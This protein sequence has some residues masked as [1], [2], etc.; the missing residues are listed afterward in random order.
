MVNITGKIKNPIL[1][2]SKI[3]SSVHRYQ[4]KNVVHF[5]IYSRQQKCHW[6]TWVFLVGMKSNSHDLEAEFM[7]SLQTTASVF[8]E[9]QS[10]GDP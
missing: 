5:Q 6:L 1:S 3:R 9:K 8:D 2:E 4:K 7:I 10:K